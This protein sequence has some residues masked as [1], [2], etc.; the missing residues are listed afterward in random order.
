MSGTVTAE[1][2]QPSPPTL[3]QLFAESLDPP[4]RVDRGQTPEGLALRRQDSTVSTTATET[5]SDSEQD[6]PGGRAQK[7][8]RADSHAESSRGAA[9]E[10][11]RTG[12]AV[13][14]MS[15]YFSHGAEGSGAAS[16]RAGSRSMSL[17]SGSS[18]RASGDESDNEDFARPALAQRVLP[19]PPLAR[20]PPSPG[21]GGAGDEGAS[22]DDRNTCSVCLEPWTVSGQH[23]VVSLKC[24]HLFG[25]SCAK[26]WLRRSSQKRI[27]QGSSS[28]KIVG[29]CPECNQRA[30]WRDIRPI[31]ARSITAVDAT[32]VDELQAEVKRLADAKLSL[33]AQRME[34]CLKHNQMSNEVVRLRRELE[35]AFQ[36]NQW[37][38]LENAN[39]AKRL[40][41]FGKESTQ[42][43]RCPCVAACTCSATTGSGQ[44]PALPGPLAAILGD[45]SNGPA[46]SNDDDNDD[47]EAEGGPPNTSRSGYFPR[48]RLRA[49]VPLAT[50]AHDSSRL[51][52]VNPH[53]Q[54]VYASYSRPSLQMHTLAQID[55]H[56]SGSAAYLLDLP[57]RAEIRGAE[58]SPHAQGA[59]YMLT[60]SLDQT[61]AVTALGSGGRAAAGTA[62]PVPMLAARINVGSPCWSCAWD[63][64]D[65]N[66]CY[67]GTT[68]SRVLAFDMRRATIPVHTWDGPRNGACALAGV[69]QPGLAT[70]YSPI[71]G[72]VALAPR[73][74]SG[75]GSGSIL[76]ANSS[77]LFALPPAPERVAMADSPPQPAA[78]WTQLTEGSGGRSCYS[79]S[80]DA[81]IGCV[82]VSFRAQDA[83]A[84][85]PAT[86]HELYEAGAELACWRR[87]RRCPVTVAS[88]QTKMART[89]VFSYQAAVHG[90]RQGLFCAGVEATRSVKA[91]GVDR[92]PGS[93]L[94]SLSDVTAGEDI[95]DVKGWQWG[96]SNDDSAQPAMF[97]SLT[98]STVRLYDVR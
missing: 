12:L 43:R 5:I 16:L 89:T 7:R 72:I 31:Y 11:S 3:T 17:A 60:A 92:R 46:G 8:P 38:E 45:Y 87:W 23:R 68:S 62:R 26:K 96:T 41:S 18:S 24:G 57:H 95:V 22:N 50:Q 4:P 42:G 36:K 55:I 40:L 6:P 82:A 29:K 73:Q 58:V 67:I 79:L 30:E 52:V 77:Q 88:P 97:A 59:R 34:H 76:V 56:N 2:S 19:G 90:H 93:E 33:E 54:L 75:S 70:G 20:E 28:N 98:N 10:S 63:P 35:A 86:E 85:T 27:Q 14:L 13:P 81:A 44:E 94:L 9:A 48:M 71:H 78:A 53:E 51:L 15:R 80:Y 69:A 39:M 65:A 21:D 66:L 1:H 25:Q 91:W 74:R 49:T 37:L 32:R 64:A 47:N 61:A 84:G 83:V